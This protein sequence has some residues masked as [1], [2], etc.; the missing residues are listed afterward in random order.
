MQE[1]EARAQAASVKLRNLSPRVIKVVESLL[2]DHAETRQTLHKLALSRGKD[3]VAELEQH[4]RTLMPKCFARYISYVRWADLHRY[5]RALRIRAERMALDPV[6]D[7]DKRTQL[8]PWPDVLRQLQHTP[9][10]TAE[11]QRLDE[12]RSML[13]ELR[14]SVFAPEV[15]TAFPISAKRMERFAKQHFERHLL[16]LEAA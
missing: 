7:A 14:V 1:F 6:K 16:T 8:E 15:R 13:E 2:S 9:L 10:S 11:Q 12:F 5:L 3:G 4:L